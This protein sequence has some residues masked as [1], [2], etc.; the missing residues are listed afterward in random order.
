MAAV[1]V[2]IQFAATV[3]VI[4][5]EWVIRAGN[6]LIAENIQLCRHR[7]DSLGLAF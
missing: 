4:T 5:C 6:E 1:I 7:F 3:P 2:F